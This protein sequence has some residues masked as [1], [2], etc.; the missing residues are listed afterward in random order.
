MYR[1]ALYVFGGLAILAGL[2]IGALNSDAASV[3]LLVL[4]FTWPLGLVIVCAFVLG[5][6]LGLATLWVLSV[7]PLKMRLRKAHKTAQSKPADLAVQPKDP[8]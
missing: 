5:L 7:L 2:L 8:L 6:L 4:E 3:D 1:I